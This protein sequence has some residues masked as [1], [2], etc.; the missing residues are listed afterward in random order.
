SKHSSQQIVDSQHPIRAIRTNDAVMTQQVINDL[1]NQGI[2]ATGLC[3]PSVPRGE[4][5]VRV[6]ITASHSLEQIQKLSASLG[7]VIKS[8]EKI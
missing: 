8:T 7:T 1:F 5:R 2:F 6:Q 4:A 3:Y